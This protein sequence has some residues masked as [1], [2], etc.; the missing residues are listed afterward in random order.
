[1]AAHVVKGPE[2]KGPEIKGWCPGALRPMESGDGWLVRIRPPGGVLT[3]AQA[4]GVAAASLAHGNGVLDLS[5]RA[6]LQLRGVRDG[7]HAGLVDDLRALGLIDADIVTEQARNVTVTPFWDAGDDTT[8][9]AARLTEMLQDA[10]AFPGK[11]GFA[12]DTGAR[13]VLGST[14]ADIRVERAA[15][16]TLILRPDGHEF[17]QPVTVENVAKAALTLLE[18]F[19]ATGGA[20][21]G[22]GRMAAH[23]AR[24]NLPDGFTT[25]PATSLPRPVPG[26]CAQGML[27]AFAF[28]QI[29]AQTLGP[30]AAPGHD[31]RM[32]PWRMILIAG[33]QTAPA[34]P[35]LITVAD[36]P[37]LRVTACT[38]APGCVQALGPT[39]SIARNLAPDVATHLHVSGCA[40]GCAHP[41]AADVT[42]VATPHGYNLIRGGAAS[43]APYLTNLPAHLI[44]QHL[45]A[46]HAPSV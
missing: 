31:L 28:G 18:W 46:A 15:D 39:R 6:N 37:L 26:P 5:Q 38:G 2:I 4:A 11:F 24:A 23:L 12:V 19:I 8:A 29:Q 33:A 42:L 10:P 27:V 44:A 22:R 21:G 45:K 36:N 41:G 9:I 30:L 40:K 7:A 20:L 14:P 1:M 3:P 13:P 17:G 35:D 32:T 16:G 34:L 25:A 43:D